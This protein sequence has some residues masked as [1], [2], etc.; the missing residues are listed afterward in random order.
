MASGEEDAV[1][2]H[3]VTALQSRFI[4]E[5]PPLETMIHLGNADVVKIILWR[6]GELAF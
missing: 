1:W 5:G 4:L 2:R 3:K 6:G